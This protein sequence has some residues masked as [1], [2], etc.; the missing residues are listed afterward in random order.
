MEARR[1][2]LRG[3]TVDRIKE[4]CSKVH[5]KVY[6]KTKDEL[7]EQLLEGEA[8]AGSTEKEEGGEAPSVTKHLMELIVQMQREQRAWLDGQQKKQEELMQRNQQVQREMVDA[9]LAARAPPTEAHSGSGRVK[10]PKPTLQKLSTSDNI[11]SYLDM[12]ERVARQQGWPDDTWATQ[13]AG[14]LSGDALDAFTSIPAEAARDYTQVKEAILARFEVNAETYRLRFRSSRRKLGE[15]Y[16]MLLSHQSDQ[17]NRWTQSSGS[18]LKENILL[19]QFL[20]SLS[21][22]LAVK[23]RERKPAT[24]KEAA[25]WA[26]DYDQAHRGEGQ[27][28]GQ[29]KPPTPPVARDESSLQQKP[30]AKKGAAG[31]FGSSF[32]SKTNS[33][34]ELQCFECRKWGHIAAFCQASGVKADAKPAMLGKRC[35]E[36][37]NSPYA[38]GFDLQSSGWSVGPGAGRH[39]KPHVSG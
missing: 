33:R 36:I 14:L 1:E 32:R 21:T 28:G 5:I 19:E 8:K 35:S 17:L 25:G 2:E 37:T 16:K 26:D 13:L 3:F 9:V 39:R 27:T 15:S 23:L 20:Q 31:S 7:I 11:E 24:A 30:F 22:D 29:V 38:A 18:A 10:P 12:F 4:L 34:G 6:G